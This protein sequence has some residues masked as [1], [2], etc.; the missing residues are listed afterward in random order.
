MTT[1]K[2]AALDA[3]VSNAMNARLA[4]DLALANKALA[5]E[6][7]LS[8]MLANVVREVLAAEKHHAGEDSEPGWYEDMQE[9]LA[10][11]AAA[12]KEASRWR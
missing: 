1:D 8:D 11:H 5:A 4:H 2:Q 9:A 6:R 3:A 10:A 12:R 7:A